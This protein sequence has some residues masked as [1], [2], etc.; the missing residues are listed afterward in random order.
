VRAALRPVVGA[1]RS[2]RFLLNVAKKVHGAPQEV[3]L[4]GQPAVVFVEDSRVGAAL[5]LDISEGRIVA[6]RTVSNP[7]K[8]DRLSRELDQASGYEPGAAR[9]G[10]R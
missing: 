2:S 7:E 3:T 6:V 10:L 9:G 5:I 4:N 8:L 1:R